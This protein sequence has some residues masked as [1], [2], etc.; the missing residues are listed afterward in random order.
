MAGLVQASGKC[1]SIRE[2]KSHGRVA[3]LY[4][5]FGY[6]SRDPARIYG[7]AVAPV[8]SGKSMRPDTKIDFSGWSLTA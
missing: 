2:A 5:T 8:A 4:E 3:L 7:N 6:A 1:T